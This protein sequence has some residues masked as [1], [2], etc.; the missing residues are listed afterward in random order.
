MDMD[1]GTARSIGRGEKRCSDLERLDAL[2]VLAG[3]ID[4]IED[5]CRHMNAGTP[6][7]HLRDQILAE[8]TD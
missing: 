8:M 4:R 6:G 7:W 5:L 3:R 2:G 1:I